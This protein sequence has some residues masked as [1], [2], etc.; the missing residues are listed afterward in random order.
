[1]KNKRADIS[2]LLIVFLTLTLTIA[3]LFAFLTANVNIREV[4]GTSNAVQEVYFKESLINFYIQEI[5]QNS[6]N[7]LMY[8]KNLVPFIYTK[9]VTKIRL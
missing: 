2:V 5:I 8:Q 9:Y 1:M 4:I 6:Y 7:R 3:A